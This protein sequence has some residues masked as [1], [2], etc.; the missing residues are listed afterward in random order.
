MCIHLIVF[1][2][3]NINYLHYFQVVL[4]K[5]VYRKG[6]DIKIY[7]KKF[8]ALIW[9]KIPT[10]SIITW[11]ISGSHSGDHK[12]FYFLGYNTIR[13]IGNQPIVHDIMSQKTEF[14]ISITRLTLQHCNIAWWYRDSQVCLNDDILVSLL[15]HF[16]SIVLRSHSSIYNLAILLQSNIPVSTISII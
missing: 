12:Q 1:F 6:N 11:R 4:T 15:S 3:E 8:A 9:K 16:I 2:L 5:N 7:W 10:Y 14:F 13:P